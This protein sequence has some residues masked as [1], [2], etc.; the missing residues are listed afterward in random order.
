V[1]LPVLKVHPQKSRLCH[2]RLT[3]RHSFSVVRIPASPH[4]SLHGAGSPAD[5]CRRFLSVLSVEN[6][7]FTRLHPGIKP[8]I[9]GDTTY[10]VSLLTGTIYG[11]NF[12]IPW[13]E[14]SPYGNKAESGRSGRE[15]RVRAVSDAPQ[16]RLLAEVTWGRSRMA[17][18]TPGLPELEAS[19]PR[20]NAW[21]TSLRVFWKPNAG[22]RSWCRFRGARSRVGAVAVPRSSPGA[23]QQA[24][25]QQR[26]TEPAR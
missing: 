1:K 20:V 15:N 18:G 9:A 7:L 16:D 17:D 11:S 2:S 5:P 21:E 26:Y 23:R 6:S 24:R 22:N 14:I 3:G 4:T 13:H 8:V 12:A 19:R 25:V 10:G